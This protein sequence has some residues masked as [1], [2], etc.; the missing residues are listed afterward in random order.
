MSWTF[1]TG[2]QDEP[3]Q[4][5]V[6]VT[7]GW[8][9]LHAFHWLLAAEE[10]IDLQQMKD[11]GGGQPWA[12]DLTPLRLLFDLDYIRDNHGMNVY[13]PLLAR[14]QEIQCD[15]RLASSRLATTTRG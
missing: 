1:T 3:G 7:Y 2:D 10:N 9:P 5:E 15:G 13:P 12:D 11:H 14:L 8:G 6:S 4:P